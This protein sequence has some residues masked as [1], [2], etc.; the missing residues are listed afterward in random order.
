MPHQ[1]LGDQGHS[2][3]PNALSTDHHSGGVHPIGLQSLQ[4]VDG[5]I[6]TVLRDDGAVMVGELAV[7][8]QGS[9]ESEKK[10]RP[11]TW[12]GVTVVHGSCVSSPL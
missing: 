5:G 8:G 1:A 11:S 10:Q 4:E 12:T 2:P 7:P 9:G 6:Q 3:S